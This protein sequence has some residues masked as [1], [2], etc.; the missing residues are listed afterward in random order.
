[1]R[2]L[3]QEIY[4]PI[5]IGIHFL[6]WAIDLYFYKGA[7]VE[8]SSDTLLFGEMNNESWKNIHR[9]LGEVFSSWVVTV[10]A[11]NFLMATRARWVERIFGGLDKMYL[12]HR[13][14]GVIAI[15]LLLAHFIVVPRDLAE[16]NPGKPLGFYAFVLI[17]IG[18]ILSAA[19]IF[20]K[21]IPYHKWI[22]IHKLM[23]VF[24]VMGVIH[25]LMVKSLIQELPITRVYVF[26]MAFIGI[27]AWFYRAFLFRIFNKKFEYQIIGVTDKQFGIT[28]I[29]MKPVSK[30]IDYLAGQFAFFT[31]P[32]ISNIEQHP[33]TISSHPYN[34]NLRITVKGLGDYTDDLRAKINV[35]GA[36]FVEGPYGHFSSSYIKERD[37]IWIAG[38]IGITPFLSLAKDMYT[39][40]IQLFW[41]VKD[42]EEAVYKEELETISTENP[43]FQYKIWHSKKLG[44]LSAEKLE[45][46][47]YNKGY[48]ICGPAALKEN[49]R[50]QLKE[51]GVPDQ[52]I[53]DEEF[54]FR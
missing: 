41:C 23:G 17:I 16:F 3:K 25:G 50:K 22:N 7:F 21:K 2:I 35:G 14:S 1:M 6:F 12:I 5:I 18:V 31:F 29:L 24:Y 48:L 54:A 34:D 45:L 38:G 27:A 10:F 30:S 28:E 37:Q 42:Q 13:R 53:Y 20:K 46:D 15:A 47:N 26:G 33:F 44:Y 43:N 49:M 8:V 36:A 9:I 19:P 52:H 40:K 39:N 11:F 32:A 4:F 51:K